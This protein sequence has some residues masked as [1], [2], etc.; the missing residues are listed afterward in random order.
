[1]RNRLGRFALSCAGIVFAG[2]MSEGIVEAG[3]P[4]RSGPEAVRWRDGRV[5]LEISRTVHTGTETGVPD[6][7]S[8]AA[9]HRAIADAMMAWGETGLA[10]VEVEV[11]YTWET[12]VSSGVNLVTF[13]DPAPFDDG[14][15][16]RNLFVSC[17]ILRFD[18]LTGEIL[19]ASV[20]FNPYKR[21]SAS[22]MAG[23]H[24]LGLVMLHE[25]GHVLGLDHSAVLDSVMTPEVELDPSASPRASFPLRRLAS[26]DRLTLAALYPSEPMAVIRG[27]VLRGGE[28]VAGAHVLAIDRRGH[29]AMGVITPAGG[30]YELGLPAGEYKLAVEPLDGPVGQGQFYTIGSAA[31]SFPTLFWSVDGG[32]AASEEW[33]AAEVEAPRTGIDFF[34]AGSAVANVSTVG[35]IENGAYWGASRTQ[36]AQGANYTL[37][38]TRNPE[39][40]AAS[41]ALLG[42]GWKLEGTATSPASAPQLLRQK[43]AP[44]VEPG[45]YVLAYQR[46]EGV[47]L[48]AGGVTVVPQPVIESAV[49]AEGY[50][51]LRGKALASQT[52]VAAWREN[53]GGDAAPGPRQLGGTSVRAGEVWLPLH[54]VSAEEITAVAPPDG[55]SEV[56]VVTGTGVEASVTV[57]RR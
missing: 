39:D 7:E 46:P 20:A 36:L 8:V 37:G 13:T 41:I 11:G 51:R 9:V 53:D 30:D 42:E 48:L 27:R 54:A 45:S 2:H 34:V 6:S 23:T 32:R 49:V 4:F 43:L 18:E 55:I 25:M 16:D 35:L 22:G 57:T 14:V 52:A 38:V 15:C 1:M 44:G 17:T 50:I 40:G 26:D 56:T 28:P 47:S 24:D 19:G 21:H 31:A 3:K 12:A 5:R 10:A 33:I 29:P